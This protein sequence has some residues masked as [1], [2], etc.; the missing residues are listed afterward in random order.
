MTTGRVPPLPRVAVKSSH[1]KS[2]GYDPRTATLD[3]GFID[4]TAYRYVG[5]PQP[6]HDAFLAAHSKGAFLR[7]AIR[8]RFLHTAL[9]S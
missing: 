3:V 4:G 6:I 5:V 7:T 9:P 2:V 8:G 1:V